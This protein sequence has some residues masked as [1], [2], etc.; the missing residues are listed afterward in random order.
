MQ[1][2]GLKGGGQNSG[3]TVMAEYS[4]DPVG[5]TGTVEK[6]FSRTIS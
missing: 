4:W 5:F 3:G 2:I 6:E 1:K